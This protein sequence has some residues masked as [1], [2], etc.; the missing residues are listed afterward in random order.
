MEELT[1]GISIHSEKSNIGV[2]VL[3]LNP[4]KIVILIYQCQDSL[5]LAPTRYWDE[6]RHFTAILSQY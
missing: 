2:Y 3:Q 5:T 1:L 4:Y 6:F